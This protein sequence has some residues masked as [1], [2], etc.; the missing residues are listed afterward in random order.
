MKEPILRGENGRGKDKALLH[1]QLLAFIS[2]FTNLWRVKVKVKLGAASRWRCSSSLFLS[3]SSSLSLPHYCMCLLHLSVSISC[4]FSSHHLDF[5][6]FPLIYS[7]LWRFAS[8]LQPKFQGPKQPS[9]FA[10]AVGSIHKAN[11]YL[12]LT[13]EPLKILRHL[14]L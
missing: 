5:P 1:F 12:F 9:N 11:R 14:F 3:L 6:S 2:S 10:S 4:P 13:Q 8:L 7:P